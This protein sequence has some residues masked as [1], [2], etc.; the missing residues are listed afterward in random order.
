MMQLEGTLAQRVLWTTGHNTHKIISMSKTHKIT[1]TSML[2]MTIMMR[3][4]TSSP[5]IASN[6]TC[7]TWAMLTTTISLIIW[8]SVQVQAILLNQISAEALKIRKQTSKWVSRSKAT[9]ARAKSR[10]TKKIER[11]TSRKSR[12]T[13]GQ[14][15]IRVTG[16]KLLKSSRLQSRTSIKIMKCSKLSIALILMV[17]LHFI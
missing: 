10:S 1:S 8:E 4:P 9:R 15:W 12:C 7:S 2:E 6:S 13:I 17:S 14:R 16:L 11:R 3:R 5:I